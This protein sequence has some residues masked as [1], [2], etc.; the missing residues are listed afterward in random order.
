[1]MK[2]TLIAVVVS[3]SLFSAANAKDKLSPQE[4][5]AKHLDSIATKEVRDAAKA[6]D[7]GGQVHMKEVMK[8]GKY[9][10]GD[11]NLVSEGSK[12]K[13]ALKLADFGYPQEQLVFDG[14]KV[15]IAYIKPGIRSALGD[16]LYA[17]QVILRD[18]L[19][20][21]TLTTGWPLLGDVT[22]KAKLSYDGLKKID[23]RP[24]HQITY[25][26]KKSANEFLSIRL[27][28]EPD[29][30]RHVMTVYSVVQPAGMGSATG[31]ATNRDSRYEL[32]E[33][34]S[35]YQTVNGLTLPT[36]QVIE[37]TTDTDSGAKIW[38]WELSWKK[39][40]GA[41]LPDAAATEAK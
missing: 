12:L 3:L 5:V 8:G 2:Q 17:Q 33:K 4:I 1:M 24:L 29:T 34:Y 27:F 9:I 20:G 25:T 16:F 30:F 35:N 40:N 38:L 39:L 18:G 41:A 22:G 14:D 23:S 37:L 31:S 6:R 19:F 28:F 11:A 13:L 36:S 26:P 32:R 15:M 21:G 10:D 7:M